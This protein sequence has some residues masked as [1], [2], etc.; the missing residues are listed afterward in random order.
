MENLDKYKIKHLSSSDSVS[1]M[2]E[3]INEN[4]LKLSGFIS[5][6]LIETQE[7]ELQQQQLNFPNNPI[8]NTVYAV[9]YYGGEW[10]VVNQIP[11][12]YEGTVYWLLPSESLVIGARKQHV[13]ADQMIVETGAEIII[14][15]TGI[16]AIV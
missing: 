15:A 3:V 12:G 2:R 1:Q 9:A 10:N 13:V 4:F 6:I 16:L 11:S 8:E 7:E 5:A 14:D